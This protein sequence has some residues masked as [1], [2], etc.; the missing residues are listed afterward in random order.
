MAVIYIDQIYQLSGLGSLMLAA[1]GTTSGAYDLPTIAA[2]FF[3]IAAFAILVTFVIDILYT[4][5]DPRV[6]TA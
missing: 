3:V 5:L 4:W 2:L 6:R 1:L